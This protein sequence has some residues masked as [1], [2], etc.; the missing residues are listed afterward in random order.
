MMNR[1]PK[2]WLLRI[3]VWNKFLIVKFKGNKPEDIPLPK[4]GQA[5][6][7]HLPLNEK[8]PD[9]PIQNVKV[10]DHVPDDEASFIK[11][12]FVE[13]QLCLNDLASQMQ[14]GLPQ[15]DANPDQALDFAYTSEH[16]K[17][18]P[19]PRLAEELAHDNITDV[20]AALATSGPFA[21]YLEKVGDDEFQ[22]DLLKLS[23]FEHHSGLKKIGVK[24]IF[25]T[26]NEHASPYP[27]SIET[28]S[29]IIS[30]N[31]SE[32]DD[33]V[34]RALCAASTHTSLVR[35]LNGL[36][37]GCGAHIAIA[38]RNELAADHPVKRLIWLSM[39][40]SQYSNDIIMMPQLGKDGDFVNMFSFTHDGVCRL[41]DE[42]YKD[43]QITS[44]NP[45][46]DLQRRG[47]DSVD[48]D[49]PTHKNLLDLFD[50]FHAYTQKYINNYYAD[51][52]AV[53]NDSELSAWFDGLEASIPNGIETITEG[54]QTR[55]S[56]A[57]LCASFMYLG[58]VD[59][60]LLGTNLWN[61]QLWTHKIPCRCY[62][63]DRREPVDVY[64]RLVNA[65]FNLHVSRVQ[66]MHDFS[67]LALD[68][69]GKA[70]FSEF[71]SNLKK[72]NDDMRA[73]PQTCAQIYPDILEANM[74]A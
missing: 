22:W 28:N 2:D 66:L 40:G 13:G 51:D 17:V 54:Q 47:L 52:A 72:L 41:L 45:K 38:T 4:T 58:A 44:L 23:Q 56:L 25:R 11:H 29:G 37:L 36:H 10:A 31:S 71:Q 65:N 63:D 70:L 39:F 64:Q 67:Y 59:H 12:T 21:A 73:M 5:K 74:N 48:F 69:V 3:K 57:E 53:T 18:F 55:A 16:K 15:I 32:W 1:I 35:H 62:T 20:L 6:I 27:Q 60:E 7:K 34:K 43:Y 9:L 68:D 42:T 30:P 33:A 24:V 50:I 19:R 49:L 46:R 14:E 61:Y 26:S 8:Y